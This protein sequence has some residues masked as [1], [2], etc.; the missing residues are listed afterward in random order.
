[1]VSLRTVHVPPGKELE[2]LVWS[3]SRDAREGMPRRAESV[4]W[5]WLFSSSEGN[6]KRLEVVIR[7]E[8]T[9]VVEKERKRMKER[10]FLVAVVVVIL[11]CD[12]VVLAC[13]DRDYLY[14]YLAYQW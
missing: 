9:R 5:W 14:S 13:T 7:E 6:M 10:W 8:R 12:K 1:M 3:S 11:T 4:L 2:V